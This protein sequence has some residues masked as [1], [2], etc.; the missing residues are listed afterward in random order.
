MSP[1]RAVP[2]LARVAATLC[3]LYGAGVLAA[4]PE[5]VLVQADAI[6]MQALRLGLQAAE[7][8]DAAIERAGPGTWVYL[9]SGN[10]GASITAASV[11]VDD[12]AAAS[13]TLTAEEA[14]A[15]REQGQ[16]RYRL[17]RLALPAGTHH[18]HA[19]VLL[20]YAGEAE[21]SRLALDQDVEFD[22]A[23]AD[24]VL[25]PQGGS[26][27]SSPSL[28][29]HRQNPGEVDDAGLLDWQRIWNEVNGPE[30]RD[31]AYRP[32]SVAD[33]LLGHAHLLIATGE[34][35]KAVVLLRRMAA[36]AGN[37]AL[38]AEYYLTL[39]D[40]LLGCDAL[41]PAQQAYDQAVAA[42]LNGAAAA[43][44]RVRIGEAYYE[45]Q[46]YA[47][48]EAAM[49]E[50]PARRAKKAYSHWQD[51]RSRILLAQNRFDEAALALKAAE[52]GADFESYVRY[53]NLG[54]ALIQNGL[55][56]QGVTV[57]DRVGSVPGN[58]RDMQALSDR[59]NLALG[60]YLL[61]NGQGATAIPVLQRIELTG[62]YSDRA[63]L[64]L[65]WAWLAPPGDKQA[66]VMLGDERTQGP[67][68]ET[69]AALHLPYDTQNVYQRYH[70]RPFVRARLDQERDARIKRA[71]VA[72]SELMGRDSSGDAVQESYLAAAVAL[73]GLGAHQEA[74][75]L[76]DRGVQALDTAYHATDEAAQYLRG[77]PWVGELLDSPAGTRVDRTLRQLPRPGV[78]VQ[79]DRYLAGWSFHNGLEQYRVLQ[80]LAAN[81]DAATA[82][83]G[84][85]E[86]QQALRGEAARLC[87]DI[88]GLK[89][90]E[91]AAL[92]QQLLDQLELRRRR[93]SKLIEGARFEV[94]RIY[95][96]GH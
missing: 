76:Y 1:E 94:A 74:A 25:A 6:K 70:L 9:G 43:E 52:A 71:L 91:V 85:G 79:L 64:E 62:P 33:P 28:V 60:A 45:R 77:G 92:R 29:L 67:P 73:D 61:Q 57:L 56:P 66:R 15:L 78:A 59:A 50:P 55:G 27:L 21:P 93:L 8:R 75:E 32:G 53:Y 96:G 84:E 22:A 82:G 65:G 63:L 86:A 2:V 18:L 87:A 13:A 14:A 24:L 26:W 3:C 51:L 7:L 42:G 35:F 17:A 38:P 83:I 47:G 30:V 80:T 48:A 69:V 49:A 41:Q 36:R 89:D 20:R 11:A 90:A 37:S 16:S 10:S 44:L 58:T 72:W 23:P 4:E 46:D 88:D 54:V 19:E 81:L 5:P 34:Q 40:A 68:P 39:S 95:D 31:G 12:A